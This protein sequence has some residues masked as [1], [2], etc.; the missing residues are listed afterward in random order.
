MMAL[1]RTAREWPRTWREE[2]REQG[3]RTGQVEILQAQSE[4]KFGTIAATAL[5]A[6]LERLGDASAFVEVSTWILECNTASELL[7]RLNTLSPPS[8]S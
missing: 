2:G 8:R 3:H 1:A 7:A 6:Q 5:A 4:R